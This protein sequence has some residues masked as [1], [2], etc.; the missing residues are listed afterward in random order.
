MLNIKSIVLNFLI[1]LF[2]G[3]I[4]SACNG[5]KKQT[6]HSKIPSH[7][8]PAP[9]MRFEEELFAIDTN[10]I[11]PGLTKLH[12]KYGFFYNSYAHDL[13]KFE[14]D[15]NDS[16]YINQLSKLI[17]HI[18]FRNFQKTVDSVFKNMNDISDQLGLA[19]AIFKQEFPERATPSY[20]TFISEFSVANAT[21][22]SLMAIGLD[23]FMKE[24]FGYLYRSAELQFPEF[25]IRKLSKN[26]IAANTIKALG[27]SQF[28]DQTSKDKRFISSIIFE[29][30]VRYFMQSLLPSTPD[31]II[32]GYTQNQVDWCYKNEPQIWAHF[33]EKN[34]LYKA[35]QSEYMRYFNDG[36]F[37]SA[38][39]VPA[40]AP[41]A[42]AVFEGWQ[43]VKKYM[44]ENPEITLNQLM[45]EADSDKIL[46]KSKYRP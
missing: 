8:E 44:N 38:D 26:Y 45:N 46:K 28:E 14:Y 41:P 31:S 21:Y 25:M 12:Q 4:I 29:G 32:L 42:I 19:N 43:I 13:L 18:P 22:D 24:K 6:T 23:M 35:E 39:G 16:I 11:I 2:S 1:L 33:I 15:R 7:Y 9:I 17:K 40:E 5:C 37:T 30:K 10:N 36:P 34:I 20:V 27:I 3:I